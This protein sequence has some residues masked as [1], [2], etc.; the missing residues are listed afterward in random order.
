MLSARLVLGFDGIEFVK[1]EKEILLNRVT[2]SQ[3]KVL[4]VISIS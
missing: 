4:E 1:V 2:F 3:W